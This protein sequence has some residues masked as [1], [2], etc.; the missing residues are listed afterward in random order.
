MTT[1]PTNNP[2]RIH[3]H[4]IEFGG[5]TIRRQRLYVDGRETPYFVDEA[6]CH[7]HRT[8]GEKYGLHGA[9]MGKEVRRR[10]GTTYQIAATLDFG[11]KIAPLK[12]KAERLATA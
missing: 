2:P 11:P 10:D 1:A 12:A 9:G 5:D 7:A 6:L 8:Y 3:W 4:A